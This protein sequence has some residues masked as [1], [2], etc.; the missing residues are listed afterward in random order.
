MN[1]LLSKPVQEKIRKPE[2]LLRFSLPQIISRLESINTSN[3]D[4]NN[5]VRRVSGAKEE[6]YVIR[7]NNFRVFFTKK[8]KDLVLLSIEN[9]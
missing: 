1:V 9:G 2:S 6:I 7:I 8:G 3:I 5:Q 4:R